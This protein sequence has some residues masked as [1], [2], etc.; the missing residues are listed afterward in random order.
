MDDKAATIKHA[1]VTRRTTRPDGS[2]HIRK[3]GYYED[4]N[5]VEEQ[6]E[7]SIKTTKATFL[8]DLMKAVSPI[9]NGESRKVTVTIE[10]NDDFEPTRI[11]KSWVTKKEYYGR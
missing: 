7:Q 5:S 11:V 1:R 2:V 8:T 10:A 9:S 6:I 3:E 4:L